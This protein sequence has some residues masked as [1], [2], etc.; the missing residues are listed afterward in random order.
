MHAVLIYLHK[1]GLLVGAQLKL[2]DLLSIEREEQGGKGCR[3]NVV[4]CKNFFCYV[5]SRLNVVTQIT[6]MSL[7]HAYFLLRQLLPPVEP[8][9]FMKCIALL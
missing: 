5:R 8:I 9:K 1:K 6:P 3:L 7:D 2:H 4:A